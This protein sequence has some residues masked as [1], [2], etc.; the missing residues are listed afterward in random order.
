MTPQPEPILMLGPNRVWRTYQGGRVLDEIEVK[1]APADS[2]FPEDWMGSLTPAKNPDRPSGEEG[3]SRVI[4][5]NGESVLLTDLF[6][7]DPSYY[8]GQGH[9]EAF[10]LDTRILV[11]FLDSAIRLHFQVHPTASFSE[12][13]LGCTSGKTEAYVILAIREGIDDPYI[14]AGF[15]RPPEREELKRWIEAQDIDSIKGCFDKIPVKPGDVFLIPGGFPHALGEGILMVELME[16]SDLAVRFEFERGGF[17]LPEESRFLGKDLDF[18]LTVFDHTPVSAEKFQCLPEMIR[19][20]PDGSEQRLFIGEEH[21]NCFSARETRI[22]K[23]ITKEEAGFYVGIV[24]EGEGRLTV[25]EDSWE[26]KPYD[27]FFVSASC[28]P[29][30]FET[31][32]GLRL[33]ECAPPQPDN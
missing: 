33:L 24:T 27:R 6:A 14:Y 19:S 17:V 25:G 12:Q 26:L 30:T 16:A 5:S 23:G 1:E 29:V 15:Q 21:T 10:G 18:A 7:E 11:K 31:S 20:F 4:R 13:F 2:H 32:D 9:Y 3:I 22:A 28:G 8:L